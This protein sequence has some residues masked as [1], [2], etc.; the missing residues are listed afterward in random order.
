M[1]NPPLYCGRM[2]SAYLRPGGHAPRLD[3]NCLCAADEMGN[4]AAT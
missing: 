3:S 2:K 1:F 4:E